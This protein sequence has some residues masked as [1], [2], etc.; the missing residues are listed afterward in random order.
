MTDPPADAP[1]AA[2]LDLLAPVL[3]WSAAARDEGRF[4]LSTTAGADAMARA[5]TQRWPPG[6]AT[7]SAIEA[8]LREGVAAGWLCG[9]GEP[10]ARFGR[11]AKPTP[12]TSG[13][14]IDV[15]SLR[16]AALEHAHPAG[17][18]TLAVAASDADDEAR[19]DG[20]GPGWVVLP[21]GSRHVPTVTSGRMILLYALPEGAIAWGAA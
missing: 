21:A 10:D 7:V 18:I 3:A 8:A 9:R 5:L 17:E 19:F 11:L 14:S 4:D 16:G 20:H 6:S 13:H 1:T 12:A 2:L 15:V